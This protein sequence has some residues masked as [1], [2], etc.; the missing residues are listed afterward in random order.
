M[1][2]QEFRII[3]LPN[4]LRVA[5]LYV[6]YTP[7]VH[8]AYVINN[9]SRDDP[10][11][12]TGMAH[13]IEHM[14]FKG[15]AKR[16]TFHILNYLESVG[17][18][19]NAYTTKEKTCYYASLSARYLDRATELLT[20]ITFH[21][22]F[23]GKEI[24]KE[25]QVIAEEI[26]MYRNTPDE[27]IFDDFDALIFGD[28]RLGQPILGTRESL[29]NITQETV[30]N[31]LNQ[32]YAAG[33]VVYAVVGNVTDKQLEKVIG[34][35]LRDLELPSGKLERDAPSEVMGTD[36]TIGIA[37]DQ[38]HEIIGGRAFALRHEHYLPF[39]VLNN[40][41]GGPAMGSMLNYNVRERHGLAYNIAS[42]FNPFVDS[43][44]W[45]IYYACE[46]KNLPKIRR[47][48]HHDLEELC[49][50]PLS[51]VRLR[52]AKNQLTGQLILGYEQL[53]NQALGVAKDLLD[54]GSVMPFSEYISAIE[55]V[56][57]GQI[58]EVAK[59]VFQD[60]PMRTIT[61]LKQA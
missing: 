55:A 34:K 37:T 42:F 53:L 9:G 51:P 4:G 13:F 54:F 6:P 32:T 28:H 57:A 59:L 61:Y 46:E 45:G 29:V 48:V 56:S 50:K 22:V 16:K 40:L 14:V 35:Y 25:K 24:S 36:L 11:Q 47:I 12:E 33:Q 20:D 2:E 17:G 39:L 19:V 3:E 30:K 44:Q 1:K 58:Q 38:A 7:A 10:R 15:T 5:H 43:G 52:Q 31:H 18:D 8:C 41:L 23:P 49:K 60:S 21:S 26:D 27:A